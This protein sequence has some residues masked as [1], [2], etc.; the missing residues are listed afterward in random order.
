LDADHPENGVLIPR[1]FTPIDA[2]VTGRWRISDLPAGVES[3]RA[4]LGTEADGLETEVA[5]AGVEI[6]LQNVE[7]NGGIRI[8]NNEIVLDRRR[9]IDRNC[10]CTGR[11]SV[12]RVEN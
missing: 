1:R 7:G 9:L 2:R 6:V 5:G 11:L 8:G 10:D 3:D 12:V 4:V